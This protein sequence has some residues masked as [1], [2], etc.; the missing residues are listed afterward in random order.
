MFR[1]ADADS[2]PTTTT[3]GGRLLTEKEVLEKMRFGR[4]TLYRRVKA[5]EFPKPIYISPNHEAHVSAS[6]GPRP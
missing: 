5:G 4:T 3:R 1:E 2:S 6:R